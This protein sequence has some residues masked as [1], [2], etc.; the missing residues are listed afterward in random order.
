[1]HDAAAK[2]HEPQ[3]SDGEEWF[4]R[5]DA[6][7]GAP[8]LS[9]GCTQCGDCCTGAGGYVLFTPD[10]AAALAR[11][12]GVGVEEFIGRYTHDTAAGR[13]LREVRSEFGLDCVFLDREKIPG[14]AVC[15][16]YEDRPMQCRTWPF[17]KSNL[18]T[19]SAWAR[20]SRS[21]PGMNK[22]RRYDVQ[23]IRILRDK[24]EI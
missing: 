12:L 21:C 4:A 8:G 22:G 20:A 24:V 23:Q 14:R 19:P 2:S 11:R 18:E 3:P 1:M 10:E 7:P 9:F 15:G 16:V 17:W 13:S 6:G 5:P